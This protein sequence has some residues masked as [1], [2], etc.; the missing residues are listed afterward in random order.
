MTE[1]FKN[2]P[3][4]E[5]VFE[6]KVAQSAI[7]DDGVKDTL[8]DTLAIDLGCT[9]RDTTIS[10]V[11]VVEEKENG[12]LLPHVEQSSQY[13]LYIDDRSQFIIFQDR[14]ISIHAVKP[15]CSWEVFKPLIL[16][17]MNQV[18]AHL[19]DASCVERLGLR[20]INIVE[21]IGHESEKVELANYFNFGVRI[22]NE[23]PKNMVSFGA[24]A[25]FQ[26]ED[27]RD[28]CRI[29]MGPMANMEKKIPTVALDLDYFL[30]KPGFVKLSEGESWLES[31]HERIESI[32]LGSTT[33]KLK[34]IFRGKK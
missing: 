16:K 13:K 11:V 18:T 15:Y 28:L 7:W 33:S 9:A 6:I 25:M 4:V 22:G 27:G 10:P 21:L 5:A 24:N 3:V 23:L 19:G 12:V 20:Y 26:Y 34:D 31:A 1:Q 14:N 2:A 32:F 29:V 17:V 30:A 8:L